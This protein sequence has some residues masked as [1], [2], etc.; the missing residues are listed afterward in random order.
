MKTQDIL[1]LGIG[2]GIA[3]LGFKTYTKKKAEKQAEITATDLADKL[4]AKTTDCEAQ[5][6]LKSSTMKLAQGA[7]ESA[8]ANFMATCLNPTVAEISK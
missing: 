6:A 8:K 3:Y 5:W 2:A 7:L 4:K 1:L